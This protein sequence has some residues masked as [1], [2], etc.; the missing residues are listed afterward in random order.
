M[1]AGPCDYLR[2]LRRDHSISCVIQKPD[3]VLRE[4]YDHDAAEKYL[5]E[6]HEDGSLQIRCSQ[7]VLR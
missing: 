2:L 3:K 1:T 4:L 5:V 7:G 6:Y